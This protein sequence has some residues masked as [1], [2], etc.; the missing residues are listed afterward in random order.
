M[1]TFV[2]V[3]CRPRLKIVGLV[4]VLE[5]VLQWK[6]VPSCYHLNLCNMIGDTKHL[7]ILGT[8]S[9]EISRITIG[10]IIEEDDLFL[11]P[12]NLSHM[13]QMQIVYC[14]R[15]SCGIESFSAKES[16]VRS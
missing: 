5:G 12:P 8:N 7:W 10:Q 16:N 2:V 11:F 1:V 14:L 13:L 9:T 6:P 4:L 15:D 3:C